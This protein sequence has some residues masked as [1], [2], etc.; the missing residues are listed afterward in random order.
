MHTAVCNTLNC[1]HCPGDLTLAKLASTIYQKLQTDCLVGETLHHGQG[2]KREI[3]RVLQIQKG[4]K[5]QG[6]V[7]DESGN[8]VVGKLDGKP[9]VK[10]YARTAFP[11]VDIL[12]AAVPYVHRKKKAAHVSLPVIKELITE[13]TTKEAYVGA[14]F[15]VKD[16]LV[17]K[18]KLTTKL[19]KESLEKKQKHEEKQSKKV[20]EYYLKFL[21]PTAN[22]PPFVA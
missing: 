13:V 9:L 7:L 15:M 6:E 2:K 14:P 18:F 16:E 4:N 22:S 1:T 19:S 12:T 17:E 10:V 20:T 5:I 11:Y 8:V 21:Y 3:V